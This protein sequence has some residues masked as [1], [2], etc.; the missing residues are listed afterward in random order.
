MSSMSPERE[1]TLRRLVGMMNTRHRNPFPVSPQ[2]LDCFDVAMSQ[3]EAEFLVRMG[4]EPVSHDRAL[5][6]SGMTRDVFRTFFD[7]LLKKGLVWPKESPDGSDLFVLPGIMLG[8]FEVFLSDGQETPEQKEFA[9][10]LDRLIRSWGKMNVFPLRSLFNK[11]VRDSEPSQSIAAIHDTEPQSTRT[12][13][14]NQT[15]PAGPIR[16]YPA[17]TVWELIDRCGERSS[18]AVV[19]CFCRQYHKLINEPC[20]FSHPPE[21]C[22]AIGKIAEHAVQHCNAR[23]LSKAEAA[24]LLRELQQKG[25]VHQVFHENENVG[26]PE[27]AICN[28]CWD[29]CGVLGSYNRGIVPLN[30]RS[31]F[32][33]RVP[34]PSLC[35]ACAVCLDFCPVGAISTEDGTSSIDGKKCIGCGQCE[36]HCPEHAVQLFPHERTVMIPLRKRSEARIPWEP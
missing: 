12:I 5:A 24:D 14:V 17:R 4:T 11:K 21:S 1:Q 34:D 10:R 22:I 16:I 26:N 19:H 3:Q 23:L 8:W 25:A 30:F 2:L 36:L 18:I 9:R 28:C 32:E 27:I 35:T 31:Y 13:P 33:A 6:I 20:R 7:G 29:C 15:V